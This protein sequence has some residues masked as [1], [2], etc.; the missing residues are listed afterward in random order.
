[1]KAHRDLG[2][3]ITRWRKWIGRLFAFVVAILVAFVAVTSIGSLD[4][5]AQRQLLSSKVVLDDAWPTREASP[6]VDITR[7]GK[8]PRDLGVF[9]Q[10]RVFSLGLDV[11][12][13]TAEHFMLVTTAS[14]DKGGKLLG[15]FEGE[16]L[17]NSSSSHFKVQLDGQNLLFAQVIPA[18]REANG[19][20]LF[21]GSID[22]LSSGE[23]TALRVARDRGWNVVACTI[24]IDFTAS[25][26]VT[27][28]GKGA[29]RLASRI[30]DHLSDR[31][32][33]L[34][35]MIK[36]LEAERPELLVGPRVVVGMSAGAIALPAAVARIGPVDAAVLI[37]GGENVAKIVTSSSLLSG[38]IELV[39]TLVDDSDPQHLLISKVPCKDP[40]K[41]RKFIE[42]VLQETKLD[43]HHTA[44]GLCGTPVL[45][46]HAE[47]DR[48]VRAETG[49][50]LYKSLQQPE[51]WRYRTG[52]IG[53]TAII[54]WKIGYVLDWIE[55]TARTRPAAGP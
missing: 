15:T 43:P 40:N 36:Y 7:S 25:E 23:R 27:V 50:E 1:M 51:R 32:Y 10:C 6:T 18:E 20:L 8:L 52:H 44:A 4:S 42:Q 53:L 11:E 31:A 14:S 41:R 33:A 12:D 49:Q 45:M 55:K 29:T 13:T 46:L 47:Y 21:L 16:G 5:A 26:K 34:E 37:G 39:E 2:K 48:I 30:D 54:P 19:V 22:V 28:N 3:N 9:G 24:G 38:H 35:A 17:A